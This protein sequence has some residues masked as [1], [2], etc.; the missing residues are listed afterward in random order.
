MVL[1]MVMHVLFQQHETHRMHEGALAI[2][3]YHNHT[4]KVIKEDLDACNM[5]GIQ[6]ALSMFQS[7]YINETVTIIREY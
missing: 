4:L 6:Q 7:R 2:P 5:Y 1:P 3:I